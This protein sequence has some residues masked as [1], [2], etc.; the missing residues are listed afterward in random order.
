MS[1]I[2]LKLAPKELIDAM[3]VVL[4]HSNETYK[5]LKNILF[6]EGD[7]SEEEF[8]TII[9]IERN[10]LKKIGYCLKKNEI[11]SRAH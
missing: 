7:L 4:M 6:N 10:F 8:D 1:T 2:D 5:N 11:V 9:S 3:V